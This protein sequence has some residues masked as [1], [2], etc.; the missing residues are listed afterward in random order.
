MVR[1]VVFLILV[2]LAGLGAAWL[3]DQHGD[4][5]LTV[6]GWRLTTSIA[7]AALGFLIALLAALLLF[8]L[9]RALWRLPAHLRR[10]H[11][12]RRHA[13]ARHAITHGLLAVGTGHLAAAQRHADIARRH[14]GDD[15]LTLLLHAQTAQLAGDRPTARQAFLAMTERPDTRLLGLRGLFVEAQ[16][17]D[18]PVVAVAI[19]EEALKL[20]RE[21]PWATHAV[22]GF[23]CASGDWGGALD[24][25]S[26]DHAAGALDKAVYDRQRAVLLTARAME[27]ETADRDAARA[28]AL[29]AVRLAPTL[30]PA[31][32]LAAKFLSEQQQIRRAMRIIETAWRANPHPDLADAYAHV[33]LGDSAQQRL[34]RI[35]MLAA[36]TPDD[37][38]GAVALARAAI[39]ANVHDKARRALEPL[40]NNPTQR[41]AMLMAELAR[42]ADGDDAL[43]REWTLRAV[44][45]RHDPAWT[46]DGYISDRW[47]PVSPVTGRLDAFQW[48]TP[49]AALQSADARTIDA[50]RSS[51][52]STRAALPGATAAPT[53]LDEPGQRETEASNVLPLNRAGETTPSPSTK[54]PAM[55]AVGDNAPPVFRRREGL[56]RAAAPAPII[57]IIRP[58]DDPGIDDGDDG[59]DDARPLTAQPD[60]WRGFLSRWVG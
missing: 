17:N 8:S 52:A 51:L 45:A 46:A 13:K 31:A 4:V 19:A 10:R 57:P 48:A 49:V 54:S 55:P 9:I 39:D 32:V 18:D 5:S 25:L 42:A 44:R 59:Q 11:H 23:R 24:L 40:L 20:A 58:P 1:T 22:L 29:E 6:N 2:G 36:K 16:R 28:D 34:A 33:R 12:E 50:A 41:V 35:E 15:P 38:E 14:A 37:V 21:A 3:A 43:A 7:V 56:D 27:S 60:G 30:V 47:R 53:A 26:R